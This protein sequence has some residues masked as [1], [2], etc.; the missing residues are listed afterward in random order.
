MREGEEPLMNCERDSEHQRPHSSSTPHPTNDIAGPAPAASQDAP[1]FA[2]KEVFLQAVYDH[3]NYFAR[4]LLKHYPTLFARERETGSCAPL[5]AGWWAFIEVPQ[6]Q[7]RFDALLGSCDVQDI[8]LEAITRCTH[9]D[10]ASH[11]TQYTPIRDGRSVQFTTWFVNHVR[12]CAGSRIRAW[13]RSVQRAKH[14]YHTN[15]PAQEA[16]TATMAVD[17]Y[18][19]RYGVTLSGQDET[20]IEAVAEQAHIPAIIGET[21]AAFLA[22]GG[23]IRRLPAR[24]A[25]NFPT[26]FAAARAKQLWLGRRQP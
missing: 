25:S 11:Y 16:D 14:V 2:T 19:T 5:G 6:A 7:R 9:S 8:L 23:R 26:D 21:V 24:P 4:Y 17:T 3:W 12:S 20:I 13:T 15:P 1:F 10:N 18:M 22:R